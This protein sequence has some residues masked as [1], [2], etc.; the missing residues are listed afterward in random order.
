MLCAVNPASN[1]IL[2]TYND[3]ED[4]VASV[5][6]KVAQAAA[7]QARWQ[8]VPVAQRG[9]V[10]ATI[11]QKLRHN[12]AF[13]AQRVSEETGK[14]LQD[15]YLGELHS[16]LAQCTW[17]L[18]HGPRQLQDKPL[19]VGRAR[20]LGR[21]YWAR[22]VPKGVCAL[23][24]PWNFPLAITVGS[25]APLL[26]AGNSVLLKP[27]PWTPRVGEDIAGLFRW[28]LAQ[29]GYPQD[30]VQVCLGEADVGAALVAHPDVHHVSFT[31]ST[32]VGREIQRIRG[33]R[34]DVP[35]LELGG[36]DPLLMLPGADIET[37]VRHA[38]WGRFYHAGQACAAVKC[39]LVPEALVPEVA[40]RCVDKASALRVGPF[41]DP[42]SQVGPLI[43]EVHRER[44][45]N[46]VQEARAQSATCLLG[47]HTLPGPG[48]FYAPTVLTGLPMA[49]PLWASELFGPVLPVVGYDTLETALAFINASP[50]GLTASVFGPAA[51]QVARHLACG[52]V[53]INEVALAHY[54]L[55]ALPWRGWKQS[56]PGVSHGKAGL[57]AATQEQVSVENPWAWGPGWLRHPPWLFENRWPL[58]ILKAFV[59]WVSG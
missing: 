52:W 21:R 1:E 37:V 32:A 36:Q 40:R 53:G 18:R 49:S 23:I 42:A 29:H 58:Q 4:N 10:L 47:G 9:Q 57:L 48:F 11:A 13:W 2:V 26:L 27:S 31:G 56:G 17:L 19:P 16:A 51:A 28:A 41:H 50:F 24:T 35:N 39:L 59:G 33:L 44:I 3:D 46:W 30:V 20:L 5:A 7:A 43:R 25:L 6:A 22:R 45:H 14:P 15:S 12:M 34:G 54:P 38:V 8:A 55:A